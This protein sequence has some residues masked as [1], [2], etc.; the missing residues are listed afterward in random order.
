MDNVG[1][2][3]ANNHSAR[4][5]F[6]VSAGRLRACGGRRAQGGG[7][8]A[9]RARDTPH[10]CDLTRP[11]ISSHLRALVRSGFWAGLAFTISITFS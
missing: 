10:S 8:M 2:V 5:S 7:P 6:S 11:R 4:S 3:A 9:W 1:A